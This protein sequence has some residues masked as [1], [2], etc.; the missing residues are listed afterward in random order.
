MT[1]EDKPAV[2]ECR[3]RNGDDWVRS[4]AQDPDEFCHGWQYRLRY[5][6]PPAPATPLPYPCCGSVTGPEWQEDSS[7]L[8]D[9]GCV[10][11]PERRVP[12]PS[13]RDLGKRQLREQRDKWRAIA[14][15]LSRPCQEC[16]RL[17]F[18]NDKLRKDR[19]KWKAKLDAIQLELSKAYDERDAAVA[20]CIEA[21]WSR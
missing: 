10:W 2:W 5:P 3:Q 4:L 15:D 6:H 8:C 1:T 18:D 11:F 19:D 21:L 9:C 20:Q 16:A 12:C 17:R 13:C 7:L 14:R